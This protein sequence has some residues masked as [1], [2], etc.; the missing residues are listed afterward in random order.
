MGIHKIFSQ[1]IKKPIDKSL[2]EEYKHI[3]T[4]GLWNSPRRKNMRNVNTNCMM[5][6]SMR[7]EMRMC[8]AVPI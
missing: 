2:Q 7:C 6:M 3:N 8:F 5:S 1:N 4:I